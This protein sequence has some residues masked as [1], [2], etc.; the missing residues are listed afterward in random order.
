MQGKALVLFISLLLIST[1]VS[2]TGFTCD[3]VSRCGL[4]GDN[5]YP[6]IVLGTVAAIANADETRTIYRWARSHGYW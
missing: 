5:S 6:N 3:E 4:Q 2:G 1:T